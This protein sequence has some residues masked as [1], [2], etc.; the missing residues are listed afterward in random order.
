MRKPDQIRADI[1]AMYETNRH[2]WREIAE[3]QMS[4]DERRERFLNIQWAAKELGLLIAE[5]DKT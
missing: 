5:L 4:S 1:E 2:A 3:K